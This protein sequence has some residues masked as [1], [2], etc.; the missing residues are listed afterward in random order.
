MKSGKIAILAAAG[1][2]AC[3]SKSYAA[4]LVSRQI[5]CLVIVDDAINC[6]DVS[7]IIAAVCPVV[8]VENHEMATTANVAQLEQMAV[9]Q[10]ELPDIVSLLDKDMTGILLSKKEVKSFFVPKVIGAEDTK[11]KGN[12]RLRRDLFF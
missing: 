4:D 10:A 12:L 6:E 2:N 9:R 8:G 5:D 1:V 7:R 3:L 11:P